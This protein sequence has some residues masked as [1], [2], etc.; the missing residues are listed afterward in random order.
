M[1]GE[2]MTT[3]LATIHPMIEPQ[4]EKDLYAPHEID[5]SVIAGMQEVQYRTPNGKKLVRSFCH[6]LTLAQQSQANPPKGNPHSF[7]LYMGEGQPMFDMTL[8]ADPPVAISPIYS[9]MGEIVVD[10]HGNEKFCSN[11]ELNAPPLAMVAMNVLL[12]SG[13]GPKNDE[14]L[15]ALIRSANDHAARKCGGF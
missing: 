2:P 6:L 1:K 9:V 14:H 5:A 11:D 13:S 10:A 7:V 3:Y 12:S 4:D 8:F 15:N